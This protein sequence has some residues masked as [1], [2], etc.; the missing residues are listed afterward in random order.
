MKILKFSSPNCAP[1]KTLN[2]RLKTENLDGLEIISLSL[3]EN[4]D[5]FMKYSVRSVPLLIHVDDESGEPLQKWQM[6][7][8]LSFIR[9]R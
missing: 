4:R 7:E 2:E 8:F 3:Y 9:S 1:C 6:N 5:M